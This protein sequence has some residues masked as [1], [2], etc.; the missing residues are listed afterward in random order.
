MN[1]IALQLQL[2]YQLNIKRI[3]IKK[4]KKIKNKSKLRSKILLVIL[5]KQT[6]QL[7]A[8]KQTNHYKNGLQQIIKLLTLLSQCNSKNL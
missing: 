3:V 6:I 2:Q 7:Q 1:S 8:N 4:L 5:K